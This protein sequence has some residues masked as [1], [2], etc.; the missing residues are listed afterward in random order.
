MRALKLLEK[1][2]KAKYAFFENGR[3]EALVNTRLQ[4]LSE[5]MQDVYQLLD[6]RLAKE[7]ADCLMT[8]SEGRSGV[9][10]I[11]QSLRDICY[12]L[13]QLTNDQQV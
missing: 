4:V 1:Y 12:T 9:G 8:L 7:Q 6:W 2:K 13:L 11:A 3:R 5:I 10:L